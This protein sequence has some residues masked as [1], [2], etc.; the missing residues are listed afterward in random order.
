MDKGDERRAGRRMK[1][2]TVLVIR[3]KTLKVLRTSAAQPCRKITTACLFP[4][5]NSKCISVKAAHSETPDLT[6]TLKGCHLN[7][8]RY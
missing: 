8:S 4:R 3:L 6:S 2:D 1:Q 5:I 7:I